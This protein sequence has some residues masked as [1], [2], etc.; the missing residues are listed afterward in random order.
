[1][2]SCAADWRA[3]KGVIVDVLAEVELPS[4]DV[5]EVDEHLM[6]F[7]KDASC[8]GNAG[9]VDFHLI[10]M[11]GQQRGKL[12]DFLLSVLLTPLE[13]VLSVARFCRLSF[14]F[15]PFLK[16]Q[17]L[18]KFRLGSERGGECTVRE[19]AQWF[20]RSAWV[21]ETIGGVRGVF[22]K[23]DRR[24]NDSQSAVGPSDC[25]VAY[26]IHTKVSTVAAESDKKLKILPVLRV[27]RDRAEVLV[28]SI[29]GQSVTAPDAFV[30]QIG[31]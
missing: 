23:A 1:M 29:V 19:G 3:D 8:T 28:R 15:E 5:T 7:E 4:V 9:S 10:K 25:R 13:I 30:N 26:V 16:G 21:A 11:P 18:W 14:C 6:L 2:E 12:A 24:N 22:E 27:V 17:S 31:T 20:W